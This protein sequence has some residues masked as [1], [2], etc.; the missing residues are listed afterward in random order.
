[1]LDCTRVDACSCYA[2]KR[3]ITPNLDKLAAEG[4]LFEQAISPAPWTLPAI[5]SLFT[6]LYPSQIGVYT[7]G[8]LATAYSS[9]TQQL[10]QN[11]YA[12]F[13]ITNN[14]WLSVDFGL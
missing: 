5:A 6:G 14:S 7:R 10:S 1:M 13:G 4:V 11:G 2:A 9:L 8:V 12:T 3:L